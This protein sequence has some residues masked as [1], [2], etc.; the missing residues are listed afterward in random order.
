MSILV[1]TVVCLKHVK[2]LGYQKT[3]HHVSVVSLWDRDSDRSSGGFQFITEMPEGGNLASWSCRV[4]L[5]CGSGF[6]YCMS[7]I[8]YLFLIYFFYFKS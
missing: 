7:V 3:S 5:G 1:L 6:F 4:Y 8:W 2:A